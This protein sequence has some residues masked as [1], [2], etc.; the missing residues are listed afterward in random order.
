MA[1]PSKRTTQLRANAQKATQSRKVTIEEVP[2]EESVADHTTCHASHSHAPSGNSDTLNCDSPHFP[3]SPIDSDAGEN[4]DFDFGNE[5]PDLDCDDLTGDRE[6]D[7]DEE[8]VEAPEFVDETAL[9]SFA[10]FLSEAQEAARLAERQRDKASKRPKHYSKNSKKTQYR[11]RV[12]SKEMEA[13]GF[14]SV[15]DFMKAVKKRKDEDGGSET[16][17]VDDSS[18]NSSVNERDNDHESEPKAAEMDVEL[19]YTDFPA[20]RRAVAVLTVK[21][22]DKKLD[23]FFRAR[24]TAMVG[25]LNL[26]LDSELSYSWRE[27]SM[28]VSK[29]QGHGSYR[30]RSIHSWIHAFLTSKKL[31]HHRYGQ[32]HSSILNDED[33][34]DS[35]KLHLQSLSAKDGHFTAQALV[36][37]VSSPDMQTKL[38]E[39]GIRKHSISVDWRY[40]HRKNGMYI[41]GHEREDV[42]AYRAAFVK[43]FLEEYEPRM[44]SYDN[45]GN[46]IQQPE[47]FVLQGKYKGQPF[48]IILVTHDESTFYANDRRK[49]GWGHKSDKG[50]PQPKGEGE[51]IMVSDFLTLDWGRLV[52]EDDEARLLFRAGKNRDG[53]F[54]SDD[55]LRQVKKAIDIF[56]VRTGGG[57]TGLFLFDNAPSHQ[58]RA[59]DALSAGHFIPMVHECA[60]APSQMATPSHSIFPTTTQ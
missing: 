26:Y 5:L 33:F 40:G 49:V 20:L 8:V 57:A 36:D 30:A 16:V 42:V 11:N 27:G 12:R 50:K 15:F 51:S 46:T 18:D 1:R 25:A 45:D 4:W 44:W 53:W 59:A 19:N 28:I 2:D 23:V 52:H 54:N 31:P 41:D 10:K 47:G 39:A 13:K 60:T 9:Q 14:K 17:M 6:L 56:E 3:H 32:Y 38:E 35:I 29:S 22:K 43:R 37:F 58:K 24:I 55:V 7:L 48:R 21:S 34:A